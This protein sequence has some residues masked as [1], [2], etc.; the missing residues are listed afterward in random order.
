MS[1]QSL[2]RFGLCRIEYQIY[3]MLTSALLIHA[4]GAS[5][6]IVPNAGVI[7]REVEAARPEKTK[8]EHAQVL[9]QTAAKIDIEGAELFDNKQLA[10][11]VEKAIGQSLSIQQLQSYGQLLSDYYRSQGW[12][13]R[14]VLP[15]QDFSS[16]KIRI[17]II[18]AR[19][20]GTEL[21]S[22][23]ERADAEFVRE[24][25]IGNQQAGS[26]LQLQTLESDLLKANDLPGILTTAVLAPGEH[27]GDT[28]IKLKLNDTSLVS[29]YLNYS[30]QGLRSIGSNQYQG[31]VAVNNPMGRGDQF[32][33]QAVGSE[34][35]VSVR[36]QYSFLLA[37]LG[38]RMSI[39]GSHLQYQLGGSFA[40][41]HAEGEGR[42]LGGVLSQ[43]LIRQAE[44]NLSASLTLENRLNQNNQLK[45]QN[46]KA[47]NNAALN[48]GLGY[49]NIE[50]AEEKNS[51]ARTARAQG[52]F[53]KYNFNLNR[54]E[55][56]NQDWQLSLAFNGQ[57]AAKNLD[58]S[59]KF[60]L[61]GPNGIRAY[62]V[63]EA[64][65]DSGWLLN[66]ELQREL[67]YGLQGLLFADTGGIKVNQRL[68]S[69]V[70]NS[71]NTYLLSGVG[72]GLRW[73]DQKHWQA[74]AL[75]G[76]PVT[77]NPA[78][79]RF[80]HNSDG[81]RAGDPAGWLTLTKFFQL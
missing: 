8:P 41:L 26:A 16:G 13:A 66:I 58:A 7:Q 79:D 45:I 77:S 68:W 60:A 65:G 3:L 30:N 72:I 69:G 29:G 12:L 47:I 9:P 78:R 32:S 2:I 67:G 11:V 25:I 75:L 27:A 23:S 51:D 28:K 43:S 14:V 63:N 40:N 73:S 50:M 70:G 10:Q 4:N 57:W 48:L 19:Y 56:L 81:T 61:G 76:L 71:P 20:S 6:Q 62:P 64:M 52:E 42:L 21:N 55:Y 59:Q 39:Y 1:M 80:N 37:D 22:E 24:Q 5:A 18:E 38:T 44:Q 53:L 74:S 49:L 15:K 17:V 46:G 33:V 54:T 34:N 35:M 36:S 31:N